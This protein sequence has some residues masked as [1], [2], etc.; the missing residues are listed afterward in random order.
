VNDAHEFCTRQSG[1]AFLCVLQ[2]L[3]VIV[4][5]ALFVGLALSQ[6]QVEVSV[7]QAGYVL[8]LTAPHRVGCVQYP[9]AAPAVEL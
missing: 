8:P 9:V 3:S 6:P 5:A 2:G 4:Q 7:L 1:N